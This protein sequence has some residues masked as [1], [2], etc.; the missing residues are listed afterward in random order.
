MFIGEYHHSVDQKGRLAV[1]VK[2]RELL[3]YGAVVTRGLDHCLFLYTASEWNK[4]AEKIVPA[5]INRE[6][7]HMA[8][9]SMGRTLISA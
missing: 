3:T 9:Y 1:P 2:F 4:L 8:R 6:V 7:K 5:K